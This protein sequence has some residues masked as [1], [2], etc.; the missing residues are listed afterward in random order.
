MEGAATQGGAPLDTAAIGDQTVGVVLT[1]GDR[2]LFY[3]PGCAALTPELR[4][5]LDGADT[6]LFDGTVYHDDEMIRAGVGQ[7]TGARMGHMAMAGPEGSLRA[8]RDL[9]VRR[10]IYVHINNTNPVLRPGSP[11]RAAVEAEGWEVACDGMA[12]E[13]GL[14]ESET[15]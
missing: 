14:R 4:R 10:K 8:F 2:R 1:A 5:R 13:G 7:K 3:I 15:S 6:V 12:L 9:C 11:E